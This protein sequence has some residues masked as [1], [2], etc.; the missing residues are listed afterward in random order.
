MESNALNKANAYGFCINIL[1]LYLFGQLSSST[2][3]TILPVAVVSLSLVL[4]AAVGLAIVAFVASKLLKE[5]FS[6]AF[7]I[8]LNAFFGFPVNVM[9]TEEA[10]NVHREGEEEKAVVSG[11]LM[12][13]ML[14]A[15]FT[16]VTI[17]SVLV[18]G[19]LVNY[20]H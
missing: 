11:Q 7:V 13:K 18:A 4:M 17:V 1:L 9:L 14:E 3:E 20:L 15:G 6:M 5:S 16:S 10:V 19:I 2:P 12:P 8:A